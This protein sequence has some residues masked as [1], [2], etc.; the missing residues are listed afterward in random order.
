MESP[1][2]SRTTT[3]RP[4]PLISIKDITLDAQ[5]PTQDGGKFSDMKVPKL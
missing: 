1:R 5:L 2:P 3:G 4:T